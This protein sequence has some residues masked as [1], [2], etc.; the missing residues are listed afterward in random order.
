M[1]VLTSTS[2][3][4]PSSPLLHHQPWSPLRHL[5]SRHAHDDLLFSLSFLPPPWPSLKFW[6]SWLFFSYWVWVIVIIFLSF[7][8]FCTRP[9]IR[10]FLVFSFH[11]W[12]YKKSIYIPNIE[13]PTFI[14]F[15]S[16]NPSLSYL[17]SESFFSYF[18]T[19][20]TAL[21]SSMSSTWHELTVHGH[22]S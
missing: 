9:S 22:T 5:L 12:P 20:Q 1:C 2:R 16:S 14:I 4:G 3:L 18:F 8:I 19:S 6:F 17:D 10:K 11:F 7:F 13:E 15:F 21:T